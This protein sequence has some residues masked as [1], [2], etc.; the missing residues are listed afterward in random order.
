[1]PESQLK[2]S[3]ARVTFYNEEN[4]YSV[5]RLEAEGDLPDR[6]ADREGLVTVTGNLPELAAGEF[7]QLSGDWSQHPKYGMQFQVQKIEQARPNTLEGIRRYLGSGMLKG[8]GPAIAESIVARFGIDTIKV[9]EEQ[10]QRLREVADIGPKRS[11]Q[12]LAAW[13]EQKQIREVMLFLHSYGVSSNLATKIIKQYGDDAMHVVEKDPYQLARDIYGV[14]FKTADGIAQSMGLPQDNPTRLEAGLVHLLNQF[15][16][17][18]HVYAPKEELLN[19]AKEL[20]SV[21]DDLLSEAVIRLKEFEFI[22]VESDAQGREAVY[23]VALHTAE[24]RLAQRLEELA[25]HRESRI[26]ELPAFELLSLDAELSEEQLGAV[27]TAL[28][29]PLSILTGGPGTGKTTTIKAL[30]AALEAG[31][32]RYAL[33]SPTGR[34]AK[35]LGQASDRPASTLHRLLGFSPQ[36][37]WK[38]NEDNPLPLDLLVVDEASMLDLNLAYALLKALEGGTHLLLVGDVDQLPSVGAGDVLREIIASKLATVTELSVIFRQAQGSQIIENAHRINQGELPDFPKQGEDFF[39]FPAENGE[40]A[41]QW[42]KELVTERI[43]DRF[44]L[45]AMR[46]VQVLSPLYRGSAGVTAL[47]SELQVALNPATALKAER[48]FFGQTMRVGD[49]LMQVKNDYEK[50]V[51]NG[52]IG[53]LEEIDNEEQTLTVDFEGRALAYTWSEADQLT[54][55]Y[56]VSVHK[57]QGS[58]FPAIVLPVLTQQYIMLQRNLLY[59]AVTR[60]KR[61]CVLVGNRK[62]IAIAVKNNQVAERWSGLAERLMSGK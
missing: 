5:L 15:V 24:V 34:A 26:G 60:A 48:G 44:G 1:M 9:I 23:P 20:L 62:A 4:G 30:I 28:Q 41:A 54:L 58:E 10:P 52:D 33:A 42:I 17:E 29:Q 56:A 36:E 39:I 31:S 22:V 55:A 7:L 40:E 47:N 12:I 46:D 14:G 3:V 18:G 19:R 51:F 25:N 43:P 11:R 6:A 21:K 2:G 38:H 50:G 37:G 13:E 32:K 45:D 8:I 16:G 59:T 49:K 53:K 27:R 57:A 35:R 61:L